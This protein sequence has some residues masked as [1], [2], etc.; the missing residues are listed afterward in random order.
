MRVSKEHFE[1]THGIRKLQWL[2]YYRKI[3]LAIAFSLHECSTHSTAPYHETKY[4]IPR[5][6]LNKR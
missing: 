2:F 1:R 6:I 5:K 4:L 3:I